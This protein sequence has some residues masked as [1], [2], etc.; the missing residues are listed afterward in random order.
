MTYGLIFDFDGLIL[1]TE[2]PALESW[3]KIY[4]EYGH[5]LTLDLWKDALGRTPG[6]GFDAAAHL[7]TLVTEPFDRAALLAQ[8]LELKHALCEDLTVLPGVQQVLAQAHERGFPCA[9]ASSSDRA[10]VEKWLRRHELFDKFKCIRT[11]DDVAAT[12][13]A[14]DLFLSAADCLGVPP[15]NC[16]VFED[17]PNGALAAR[18]AGM[19]CIAVPCTLTVQL[20]MPPVD[21][22]LP[23]LDVLPLDEILQKVFGD[24]AATEA[25]V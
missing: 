19:R 25:D 14:P 22:L 21:L 10:W 9:V 2:T 16:L 3:R 11:A 1:D 20:P 7:A 8:R 18:A 13:P 12:K 24:T 23:S 17:S 4:A 6:Q 5:D 15:S